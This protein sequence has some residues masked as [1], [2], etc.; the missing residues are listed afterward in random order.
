MTGDNQLGRYDLSSLAITGS[1]LS[2]M[3][4]RKILKKFLA[5]TLALAQPLTANYALAQASQ[6]LPAIGNE[7]QKFG[8]EILDSF[9]IPSISGNT[10]KLNNNAESTLNINDLFPGT[11]EANTLPDSYYFPDSYDGTSVD[12]NK[13]IYTSDQ[14]MKAQGYGS[15]EVL[16]SDAHSANPSIQGAAYGV[17]IDSSNLSRPDMMNDPMFNQTRFVADNLDVFKSE[18]GDCS[19]NTAFSVT[20][21]PIHMPEYKTCEKIVDKSMAC[22]L[23]HDLKVGVIKHHSGPINLDSCGDNCMHLWIGKRGDNYWS[24]YCSIFEQETRVEVIN[25]DA[26]V[27]A[28]LEYVEYDDYMQVYVGPVGRESLVWSGPN[29]N[30]PPETEG[31]CELSTSWKQYPH[32]DVTQ[33]FKNAKEGDVINFKI[34]VSVS[35]N[36]E[37]FGRIVINYDRKKAIQDNGW[38]TPECM[39]AG[40]AISDNFASGVLECEEYIAPLDPDGCAH[41]HGIRVCESDMHKPIAKLSNLCLRADVDADYNFYR[42]DL[43]CWTDVH[44]ETHC[45]HNEGEIKD[46]CVEYEE[47]PSCGFISSQCVGKAKGDSGTCYLFEEVYDCG[48]NVDLDS[49]NKN[50][51]YQCAGPI[52]CMGE[53]CITVNYE[54]NDDFG[55]AAALLNAAQ[56]MA[57]D[58]SCSGLNED[59]S[60]TGDENVTCEVFAG[61]GGKCKKAVGGAINCCKSPGGVSLS[62]YITLIMATPKLDAGLMWLADNGYSIGSSYASMKG[63]VVDSFSEIAKPFAGGF[64]SISSSVS[65]VKDSVNDVMTEIGKKID[66]LF[67]D[68]FG[69]LAGEAGSGLAQDAGKTAATSFME[70]GAGQALQFISTVYTIYSVTMLVMKIIFQCTEDELELNVKRQLKSCTYLGSYC[71]TEILGVCVEKRESYCCYSS[72]LSRI[73]QE[74]IRPQLGLSNGTPEHPQCGGLPIDRFAEVNWDY[75]NLDEWLGILQETGNWP[76]LESLNI[77]YLTGEGTTLDFGGRPDAAERALE[78]LDDSMVDKTRHKVMETHRPSKGQP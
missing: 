41:V 18:F 28:R 23:D 61:K 26:I 7:S 35:G 27:S 13:S 8:Q 10:V 1:F 56:F 72:P 19:E 75:V 63:V 25:S 47:N 33:H 42:G 30:F 17:L 2:T 29:G 66:K 44:G 60:F 39:E 5:I 58:I 34:R 22:E 52:R 73:L 15:Q 68:V 67:S 48:Y 3:F 16:W 62:D 14:Q 43:D 45:P 71:H 36:G 31:A 38:N 24:G 74:Q 77:P 59:G 37:G 70:T 78:R 20:D 55:Q 64:D 46:S 21:R 49:L 4:K 6:T 57:Q 76:S 11:S 9:Q 40:V 54:Q 69:N 12:N 50:T 32:V 51:N 53:E 65:A